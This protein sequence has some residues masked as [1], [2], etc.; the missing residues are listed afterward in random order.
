MVRSS[1]H[2]FF[3]H[4]AH[5]IVAA[6]RHQLRRAFLARFPPR[7]LKQI[8]TLGAGHD[9]LHFTRVQNDL[10]DWLASSRT[11]FNL[12][13]VAACI[14]ELERVIADRLLDAPT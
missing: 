11:Q 12:D 6:R 9:K 14:S 10:V 3:G 7:N 8:A 4:Q 2:E 13:L 1:A 5:W